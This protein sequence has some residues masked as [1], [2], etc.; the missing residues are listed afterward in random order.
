MKILEIEASDGWGGQEKRILEGALWMRDQGHQ[1][2]FGLEPEALLNSRAEAAGFPIQHFSFRRRFWWKTFWQLAHFLLK[3]RFDVVATH[4]SL[5][6]WIGGIVAKICRKKV[7][8]TRHV[9]TPIKSG[10]NSWCL[11]N[12]LADRTITTCE[13]IVPKIQLQAKLPPERCLSIP[14]GL[15]PDTMRTDPKETKSWRAR[16]S[17]KE[18]DFVVGTACVMRSWKGIEDL[19]EAAHLLGKDPTIKFLLIGGG[20]WAHYA[21][22]AAEYGLEKTVFFTG[23]LEVPFS[24]MDLCD[25]FVLLST[26]NEGVSQ[27]LLQAAF[28]QK[29]LIATSIGGSPEVCLPGKTGILVPPKSPP[30]VQEA[31][32]KMQKSP[33]WREMLG[34]N[35]K[36]LVLQSFTKAVMG[37]R[38]EKVYESLFTK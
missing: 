26:A 35:G 25:A 32:I 6:A 34:K 15:A 10:C 29:P 33:E 28:L 9:S 13:E 38:I 30:L 3:E 11:Y 7:V 37:E 16:F 5:D 31:I 23:H 1:V 2:V 24:A 4:S 27:A 21:K 36:A 19:I 22:K 12:L 17:I 14:T 8:R 20:N 18:T